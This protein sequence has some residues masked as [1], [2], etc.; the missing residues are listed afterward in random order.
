MRLTAVYIPAEGGYA[1]YL[2]E[3]P[4]VNT[5]GATINEAR[6]NLLDALRLMNSTARDED[7]KEHTDR[8]IIRERL[9]TDSIEE[10]PHVSPTTLKILGLGFAGILAGLVLTYVVGLVFGIAADLIM[11]CLTAIMVLVVMYA[12][13]YSVRYFYINPL[14]L[15]IVGAV[16]ALMALAAPFLK[17]G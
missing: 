13:G 12:F 17:G 14:V 7:L 3:V 8:R 16:F 2:V 15:Y 4:G 10:G 5:Q 9:F 6:T 11:V 1:A